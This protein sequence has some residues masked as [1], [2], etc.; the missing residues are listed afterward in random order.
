[1]ADDNIGS[2]GQSFRG[3]VGIAEESSFATSI[4]PTTF[5]DAMSEGFAPSNNLNT[6]STIRGGQRYKVEPGAVDDEGDVE[7]PVSPEGILPICLKGVLGSATVVEDTT[8]VGK[9]TFSYSETLPSY[10]VEVGRGDVDAVRHIGC[11]VPE[12]TLDHASEERL[13]ATPS[14]EAAEP[15]SSVTAATP[16]YDSLRTLQWFDSSI[17]LNGTTRDTDVTGASITLANGSEHQTRGS[18]TA[19]KAFT[20]MREHSI[21][22]DLDFESTELWELFLGA[23]GATSPKDEIVTMGFNS[24]WTSTEEIDTTGINYSLEID[25]PACKINTHEASLSEQEQIAEGVELVPLVD[26]TAG[27]AVQ[28]ILKNSITTAY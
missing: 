25:A 26:S 16:T 24:V 10:S 18:R 13:T 2:K 9:H 8:G 17:S 22:V 3:Y 27:Y 5:A 12:L 11:S 28:A 1:M 14:F 20:G 7:I 19:D 4:A 15:D 23:S 21:S 6:L